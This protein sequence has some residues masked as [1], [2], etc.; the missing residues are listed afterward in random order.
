MVEEQQSGT[1]A[2]YHGEYYEASRD[3]LEDPISKWYEESNDITWSLYQFLTGKIRD[4]NNKWVKISQPLCNAEGIGDIIR[5]FNLVS[6]K[7]INLG[8]IGEFTMLGRV[9]SSALSMGRMLAVNRERYGIGNRVDILDRI[10]KGYKLILTL[11][12]SRPFKGGEREFLKL[13]ERRLYSLNSN[14]ATA[15]QGTKGFFAFL[16]GAGG[17]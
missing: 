3:Q 9:R 8:N 1:P 13:S 4:E 11:S 5:E 16:K 15:D 10:S 2:D 12:L 17:R 14:P 7:I 6:N